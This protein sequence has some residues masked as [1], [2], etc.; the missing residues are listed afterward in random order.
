MHIPTASKPGK[1]CGGV[2]TGAEPLGSQRAH[3]GRSSKAAAQKKLQ[4]ASADEEE[5]DDEDD[6]DD[7]AASSGS[8]QCG[9]LQRHTGVHAHTCVCG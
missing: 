5:V 6:E 8:K 9:E 4:E 7:V 1:P 3:L 2:C